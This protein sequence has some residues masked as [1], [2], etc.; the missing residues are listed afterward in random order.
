MLLGR[1]RMGVHLAQQQHS[2]IAGEGAAGKIS[3]DLAR[4]QVLK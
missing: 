2:A 3:H 4:T 1:A